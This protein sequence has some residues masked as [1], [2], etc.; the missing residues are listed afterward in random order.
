MPKTVSPLSTESSIVSLKS[1]TSAPPSLDRARLSPFSGLRLESGRSNGQKLESRAL[2]LVHHSDNLRAGQKL[3]VRRVGISIKYPRSNPVAQKSYIGIRCA[4]K[5]V[6]FDPFS[7]YVIPAICDPL[8]NSSL[9]L[10]LSL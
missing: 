2:L 4:D 10:S 5:L 6:S 7:K 9:A 1:V 3:Y 8:N